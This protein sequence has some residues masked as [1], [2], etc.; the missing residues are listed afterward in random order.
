MRIAPFE[1]LDEDTAM[2]KNVSIQI[3]KS[4]TDSFKVTV[5]KLA[6]GPDKN[7]ANR[8]AES[9]DFKA[10]Q[11]DSVLKLSEGIAI[12]RT[13]KFRNQRVIV[14]I[15]VPVGKQIRVDRSMGWSDNVRLDG[16]WNDEWDLNFDNAEHGWDLD[17]DYIMTRDGLYTVKGNKPADE[18]RHRNDEDN[19]FNTDGTGQPDNYR[20]DQ[21]KPATALDSL[22]LKLREE[23]KRTR[24]SLRKVKENVDE[25]LKRIED[26]SEGNTSMNNYVLPGYNPLI[27]MMY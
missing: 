22:Q 4:T 25:Q 24:D 11:V 19:N 3:V 18:W 6:D 15:Y 10:L 7:T 27:M 17:V 12:N 14:T 13:N 21:T 16:P 2:V 26:K 1:G 20:Y 5:V 23:E 9:I 8:L